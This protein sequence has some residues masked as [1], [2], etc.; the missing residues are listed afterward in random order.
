MLHL[1]D[2]WAAHSAELSRKSIEVLTRTVNNCLVSGTPTQA[3]TLLIAGAL[4]DT[5]VGLV[6]MDVADLILSVSK[7]TM[8]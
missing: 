3:E 8:E 4:Y 5:V 2:D 6:P 1:N 7:G